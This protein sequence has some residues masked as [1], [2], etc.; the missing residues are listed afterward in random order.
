M[1]SKYFV[2]C[3]LTILILSSCRKDD[4]ADPNDNYCMRDITSGA[5]VILLS[6]ADYNVAGDLFESNSIDYSNLQFYRVQTEASGRHHIRCHQYINNLKL[7]TNDVIFHFDENDQFD[8]ISGGLIQQINL[9]TI[10]KTENY[11]LVGI[12]EKSLTEDSTSFVGDM[13]LDTCCFDLEFGY[14]DLNIAAG[15]PDY[16]F[17]KVWKITFKESEFPYLIVNDNNAEPIYYDNGIRY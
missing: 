17:A 15:S 9:D 16:S 12:F 8:H 3:V 1:K 7:F 6:G 2:F 5:G 4:S 13:D 10:A 14:Y 11:E